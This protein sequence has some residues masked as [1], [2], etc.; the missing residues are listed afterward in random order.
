MDNKNNAQENK[1]HKESNHE[2]KKLKLIEPKNEKKTTLD[3]HDS[4]NSKNT[5]KNFIDSENENLVI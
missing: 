4:N 1:V 5:K 2:Y 3:N